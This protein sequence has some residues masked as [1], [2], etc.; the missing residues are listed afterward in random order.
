ME[1][2]QWA[3]RPAP[4]NTPPASPSPPP[5]PAQLCPPMDPRG[6][7]VTRPQSS[8]YLQT[9]PAPPERALLPSA[10]FHRVGRLASP[11]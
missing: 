10:P 5:L 4:P 9:L 7:G 3:L 2:R 1:H 11:P 6:D 8:T